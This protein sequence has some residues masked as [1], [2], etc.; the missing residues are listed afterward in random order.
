[1]TV[2]AP[3]GPPYHLLG[4]TPAH[5][6]WRPVLGTVVV[7]LGALFA[8]V[9][10]IVAGLAL[11]AILDRPLDAEG[12]PEFGPIGETAVLLL[13]LALAIP[14]VLFAVRFVGGRPAGTVSSVTGRLRL[15]WLGICVLVA[16]PCVALMIVLGFGLIATTGGPDGG[17]A[18]HW[19]GAGTF[20]ASL[21][22][23]VVLVPF[24]AAAEEY[25]CRG[26]LLQAVGAV[27]RRPWLAIAPQAV[28]FAAAHGWGTVWGFADLVVF[29]ALAGW[30]TVRT[31]G[32]EAAIALHLVNNVLA[33]GF[34]AAIGQLDSDQTAADSPWQFVVADVIALALY[35]WIVLRLARRRQ[36]ETVSPTVEAAPLTLDIPPLDGGLTGS[37]PVAVSGQGQT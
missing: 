25:V 15:G 33:M 5:R 8:G 3:P 31:G 22:M 9:V 18:E 13:S 14:V 36:V 35:T 23:L 4:R 17:E 11:A 21:A 12:M 37:R 19:V 26:W 1:M 28:L 7:L 16:L 24:Q 27:A 32:L 6:W 34:A 30:L 20:V 29:G 2:P 10:V